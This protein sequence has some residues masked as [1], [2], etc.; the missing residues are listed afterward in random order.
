M[1]TTNRIRALNRLP[2]DF[3]DGLKVGGVDVTA[4]NQTFTPA[5]AGLVGFTPVGNL[6][7]GNVQAALAE[8]ESEK[9]GFARLDDTDGSSLVGYDTGTVQDVLDAVTGPTGGAS[10]GYTPVGVGAVATN[11]QSKLRESVSIKDFGGIDDWDGSSGTNNFLAFVKI[12]YSYPNGVTVRMPKTGTGVYFV[13]GAQYT[14]SGVGFVFD[15]DDGVSI[16][17]TGGAIPCLAAGAR[18]LKM[19]SI[20]NVASQTSSYISPIEYKTVREKQSFMTVDDGEKPDVFFVNHLYATNHSVSWPDGPVANATPSAVSSDATTWAANSSGFNLTTSPIRPGN[21]LN[22]YF[23][24]NATGGFPYSGS[25]IAGVITDTGFAVVRQDMTGG[26]LIASVKSG[27]NAI[28]ENGASPPTMAQVSYR[29]ANALVSVRVHST[30]SFSVLSNGIEVARIKD[31]GGNILR[32]G[33][34]PGFATSSNGCIVAGM[35]IV[36]GS[37]VMGVQPAKIVVVGDS[38]TDPRMGSSWSDFLR[39]YLSGV[40]GIQMLD[41]KNLAVAGD[42]STSQAAILTSTNISGYNYCLIQIGVN[43]IQGGATVQTLIANIA[44]MVNYCRT[45]GVEPIVG[46]PTMW[47][48]QADASGT[49]NVGAATSNREKGSPYRATLLRYLSG[50]GV[51]VNAMTLSDYGAVLPALI[52]TNGVDSVVYDNIHPTTYGRMVLGYSWAKT[53]IGIMI[54]QIK[55][56]VKPSQVPLSW[57]GANYGTGGLPSYHVDSNTFWLTGYISATADPV[58]GDVVA[59]LPEVFAPV[60]SVTVTIPIGDSGGT[61]SGSAAI[62]ISTTGAMKIYSAPAGTRYIYVGGVSFHISE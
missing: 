42:N 53:L 38:I 60:S 28:V 39:Q 6:S 13:N 18:S 56:S 5:G 58:S 37:R 61:P 49:G 4:L 35:S 54:P 24:D 11:V 23:S 45:N 8:L 7:A 46:I 59:T 55:K 26:G 16:H 27:S 10:V 32:A 62:Q 25:L 43:D 50:A 2:F 47:Y 31:T 3:Q 20:R 36:K 12:Y 41:I 17:N 9:V 14:P 19:L 34:G 57:C 52:T 33:F 21:E 22:C 48:S 30:T 51:S 44:S 1:A 15:P 40:G 29:F